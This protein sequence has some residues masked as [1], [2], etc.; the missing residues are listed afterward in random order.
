[1]AGNAHILRDRDGVR[2][3]GAV[4][5]QS[6]GKGNLSIMPVSRFNRFIVP[7]VRFVAGDAS[8]VTWESGRRDALQCIAGCVFADWGLVCRAIWDREVAARG[9]SYECAQ[10]SALGRVSGFAGVWGFEEFALC[11]SVVAG[12]VSGN[13]TEARAERPDTRGEARGR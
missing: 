6:G 11:A 1:M 5:V 2:G 10:W 7:W 4:F 8:I 3:G 12:A 9:I 13:V